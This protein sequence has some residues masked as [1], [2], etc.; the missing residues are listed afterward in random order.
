MSPDSAAEFLAL[1]FQPI[2]LLSAL[3]S[4]PIKVFCD[5]ALFNSTFKFAK[6]VDVPAVQ[7]S[8]CRSAQNNT[9]VIE[10]YWKL[11]DIKDLAE[12]I[13]G[14][15]ANTEPQ[16]TENAFEKA[17]IQV[18]R[19]LK[20][21]NVVTAL[22]QAF[23]KQMPD[24]QQYINMLYSTV[25]VINDQT[26]GKVGGLCDA[27]VNL[28]DETEYYEM[29]K[30]YLIGAQTVNSV[31]ATIATSLDEFDDLICKL[32]SM[33]I[34]TLL[35]T[36]GESKLITVSDEL[37]RLFDPEY[38]KTAEFQCSALVRDS[39]IPS[40]KLQNFVMS[41][42]NGTYQQCFEDLVTANFT[43]MQDMNMLSAVFVELRELLESDAARSIQWLEP[44]RP[45][46]IDI[47]SQLID[48]VLPNILNII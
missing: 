14:I 12:K 1:A 29:A 38:M 34:S 5:P 11:L 35:T 15:Q 20:N 30:P 16:T 31:M 8:L 4:E 33:N 17:M 37:M 6:G 22:M 21:A 10:K 41:I 48:Q 19:L 36:I 24:V 7:E 40:A 26:V 28:V 43:L 13:I 39:V 3:T 25:A 9:V 27:F 32:P 47:L 46:L 42:V 2:N 23:N 18:E 45:L 44:L